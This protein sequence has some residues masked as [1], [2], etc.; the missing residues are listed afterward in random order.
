MNCRIAGVLVIVLMGSIQEMG[1]V[2]SVTRIVQ[3]AMYQRLIVYLAQ[4]LILI[5]NPL[6]VLII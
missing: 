1:Y 5:V 2:I 6:L 3:L 4:V